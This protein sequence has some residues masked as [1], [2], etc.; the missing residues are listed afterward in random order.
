MTAAIVDVH[1]FPEE[2]MY[3]GDLKQDPRP[4]FSTSSSNLHTLG[5]PGQNVGAQV[6][7][8]VFVYDYKQ[9]QFKE[10]IYFKYAKGYM[11]AR[12]VLDDT[13]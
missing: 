2:F 8:V 3:V 6:Q 1:E 9:K 10:I 4:T 12:E 11:V 13:W 5:A 7:L